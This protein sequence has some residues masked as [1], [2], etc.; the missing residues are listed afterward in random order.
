MKNHAFPFSALVGQE[1]MR[2]ALILNAVDPRV[3]GVLIRGGKGTAKTT[4]ARA[5]ADL[6]PEKGDGKRMVELPL[7]SS[8]DRV[9]G[10]LDAEHAIKTGEI[11]FEPGILA[12]ADGNVLYVDEINLLEDRI[13]DL[14]L[15]ASASGVNRVERDGISH[16]HPSRFTLIGTMNPDEGELRPQFLER[17][18]MC[19]NVVQE[20]DEG[21]RM[22]IVTRRMD[23]ERDPV[24]FRS[25][26]DS[27]QA[28]LRK[29]IADARKLLSGT[30]PNP[31]VVRSAAR[32]VSH[33]GVESCRA[34]VAIVRAAHARAAFCG[35]G[36]PAR[37]DVL[38]A[39][40][41]VMPHRIETEP[42]DEDRG[43]MEGFEEW[44]GTV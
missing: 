28:A 29:R 40:R 25:G 42:F 17:F 22:E 6:L 20:T 44:F 39:T 10:M 13:V 7:G 35:M 38:R 37:E 34:D 11:R 26:F 21:K 31:G 9:A 8:E 27:E 33:L 43:P 32:I 23:F 5:L 30:S 24:T 12:K 36:I 2:E 1:E 14:L 16:A 3:G 41:L 15:E 19:V 18:G 4:A